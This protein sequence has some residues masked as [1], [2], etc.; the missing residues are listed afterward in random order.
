MKCDG[1]VIG[2]TSLSRCLTNDNTAHARVTPHL[3]GKYLVIVKTY[4][5]E[6]EENKRENI[7]Y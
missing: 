2:D 6:R 5:N 3:R 1:I 4:N 7:V